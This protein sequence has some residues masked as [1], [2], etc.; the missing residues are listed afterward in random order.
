M[1][2]EGKT[3]REREA[4]REPREKER[5]RE[6]HGRKKECLNGIRIAD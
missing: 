2:R 3:E 6:P 4:G 1:E 5:G